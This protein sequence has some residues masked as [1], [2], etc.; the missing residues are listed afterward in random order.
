[1]IW[2][3]KKKKGP[4]QPL[5]KP[6]MYGVK[7]ALNMN[8]NKTGIAEEKIRKQKRYSKRNTLGEKKI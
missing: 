3:K 1:M 2:K 5:T 7:N 8:N 4:N 6:I